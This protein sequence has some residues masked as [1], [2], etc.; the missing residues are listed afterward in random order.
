MQGGLHPIEEE[1]RNSARKL[2][3][4]GAYGSGYSDS[5][6]MSHGTS[7]NRGSVYDKI[8]DGKYTYE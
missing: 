2:G 4:T 5:G 3:A 8:R 6:R 7:P 1:A